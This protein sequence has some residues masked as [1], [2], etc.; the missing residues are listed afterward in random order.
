[1]SSRWYLQ[2]LIFRSWRWKIQMHGQ[3]F[4]S[5][6]RTTHDRKNAEVL[7]NA[8]TLPWAC[9]PMDRGAHKAEHLCR[10]GRLAS[11]HQ[12]ENR[13]EAPKRFFL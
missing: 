12:I 3:V 1:M 2:L 4:Q 10:E 11:F 13:I 5:V 8:T 7:K 6:I 9:H